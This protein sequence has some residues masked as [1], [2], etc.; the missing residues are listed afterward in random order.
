MYSAFTNQ[1]GKLQAVVKDD[2]KKDL[3][4]ARPTELTPCSWRWPARTASTSAGSNRAG[5]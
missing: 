5:R 2:L 3:W 1:S 4:A